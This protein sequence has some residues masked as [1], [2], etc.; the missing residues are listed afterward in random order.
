MELFWS[1]TER[2]FDIGILNW[3]LLVFTIKSGWYTFGEHVN[4]NIPNI[5][6]CGYFTLTNTERRVTVTC[7]FRLYY[8]VYI[9]WVIKEN[10][11]RSSLWAGSP[12][13]HMPEQQRAKRS[14]GKE[15]G[16]ELPRKRACLDL[17]NFFH[18]CFA[19]V[20]WNTI[21]WK[22]ATVQKLSI[23]YV[24]WGPIRSPWSRQFTA[25]DIISQ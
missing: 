21:G 9:E 8:H 15:C 10:L 12:L 17:C 24:W 1:S 4:S 14:G 20:R 22:A 23:Y 16:E 7:M 13:S 18:L 5:H 25:L 11:V 3:V 19:W 2:S 6:V